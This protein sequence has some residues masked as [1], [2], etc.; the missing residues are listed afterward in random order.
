MK[1][2]GQ[3]ASGKKLSWQVLTRTRIEQML[4][5]GYVMRCLD[6]ALGAEPEPRGD[7]D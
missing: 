6:E 5:Y 4:R 1:L 7:D 3:L 2:Q